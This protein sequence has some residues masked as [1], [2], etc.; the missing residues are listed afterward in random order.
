MAIVGA[1]LTM[2]AFVV[3]WDRIK[4]WAGSGPNQAALV[5]QFNDNGPQ[6]AYVWGYRWQNGENPSGEDMFRA[7]AAASPDLTLFTQYTGW[8]GNTVCGIGYSKYH[9]IADFIEYDFGSAKEDGRISFNYFSANTTMGQTDV[10]GWDTQDLCDSAIQASKSSHIIDHPINARVYGY[11]AYDYDWWQA[12]DRNDP[13]AQRWNAGWY[14]GYWSYWVGGPDSEDFA[15]SGLGMTSRKLN[16]GDVDGWKYI[17]LDG[18]V[19]LDRPERAAGQNIYSDGI[20]G[21]T[22]ASEQWHQLNYTHFG[23]SS[24]PSVHNDSADGIVEVYSLSGVKVTDFRTSESLDRMV[25]TLS[26]GCYIL[27]SRQGAKKIFVK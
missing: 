11:P 10:P 19:V 4:Y 5:V 27:R 16:N 17:F 2:N 26:S 20:D 15:Y 22:G 24:A 6:E 7:V 13:T 12:F 25:R 23:I 8:M 21:Y 9:T 3:E 14:D 18:P 1:A